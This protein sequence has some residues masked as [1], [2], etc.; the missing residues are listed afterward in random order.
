MGGEPLAGERRSSLLGEESQ[1]PCW[2][3][4]H[5]GCPDGEGKCCF[6]LGWEAVLMAEPFQGKLGGKLE[7]LDGG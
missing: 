4:P 5:S 7:V 3:F 1:I 2:E 6:R